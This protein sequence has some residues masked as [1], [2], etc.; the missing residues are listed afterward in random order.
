ML[1]GLLIAA[2]VDAWYRGLATRYPHGTVE[3]VPDTGH[4]IHIERPSL[5][6]VRVRTIVLAARQGP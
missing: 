1:V 3:I 4:L 5:V 2:A 6:I